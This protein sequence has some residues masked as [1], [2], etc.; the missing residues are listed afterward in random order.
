MDQRVLRVVDA[1]ANRAREALRVMED[2][3]RF[4]LADGEL[5]ARIKG[6]RHRVRE[7]LEALGAD[8]AALIAWRDTPGDPGTSNKAAREGE[9][10]GVREVAA[11]S[12]KRAGEALRSL[13]ECAKIGESSTGGRAAWTIFEQARYELYDCEQR[14]VLAL[15]ASSAPRGWRLCVLVTRSMC[16]RPWE[17]VIAE[18]I[19]GGADAVQIREKSAAVSDRELLRMARAARAIV[20]PGRGRSPDP[21]HSSSAS[22][23]APALII[24]DRV[25]VAILSGADGVHLGQDDLSVRDVRR[26]AGD[27]LLVG[28]STHDMDEARRAAAD[29]ADYCGVG[30]MFPTAT[31]AR[32]VSGLEYVKAYLGDEQTA[33]VPHL[34]IG[35]ITPG[36]VA[37]LARL[38]ARGVAVS[39]AVCASDDPRAVC[40]EIVE[41]L[42]GA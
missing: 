26:L 21:P 2:L 23:R 40:R 15:G 28:V 25:D 42:G 13:E 10:A 1:S 27:R 9:R 39:G 14:L 7:G 20:G 12:A 22:G 24:N 11:A 38:G 30:A 29:G 35:G 32:E 41:A 36:N 8:P 17:E 18:S 34:C 37:V 33:R 5:S 19:A 3:A 31:K 4:V 16:K 6:L